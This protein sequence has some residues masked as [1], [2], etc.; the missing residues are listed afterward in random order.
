MKISR[1]IAA[2]CL[3]S[4]L[5]GGQSAPNSDA[6]GKLIDS[7]V[8]LQMKAE[9][10]PG[11]VLAITDRNRLLRVSTYG[12]ANVEAKVPATRDTLFEIGSISKSFT[13]I[14]LLQLR[15]QGKFDP[16][17]PITRYL[18]WFSI[19][20]KYRPITGHDIMTHTAGLP[21]DRDDVPSSLYQAAGVRDR[22]TGY[23]PGK[24]F[25]YSNIGYQI[26]GYVLQEITGKPYAETVRAHILQPLD[27]D[28]SDAVFT[29]DTYKR[30]AVGYAPLYDDR[31]YNPAE[32]LIPATWQEYAAGDGSVVSTAPDL[33]KY[34]RMLLNH[35]A[36]PSG[37]I[38]SEESWKLLTQPAAKVPGEENTYYGYGIFSRTVE[39]HRYIGHS[40]G[41][42]GYSARMEGDLDSGLGVV[43]LENAPLGPEDIA[44]FALQVMRAA[45]EGKPLPPLPQA[46]PVVKDAADYAGTYTAADGS[47]FSISNDGGRLGLDY[48]GQKLTLQARGQDLFFVNHPDFKLFNLSFGRDKGKIVEAF[49][50]DE[51]FT[52][53]RYVGLR[54]FPYP[55]QW[56]SYLGHYRGAPDNFRVVL[57]KGKLWLISAEGDEMMLTPMPGYF[58]LAHQGQPARERITFDTPVHGKTLRATLSGVAYY[59]TFTP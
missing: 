45:A 41:M 2:V 14:A 30:L 40:G 1:L 37:R 32:P 57:R 58:A 36:G 25:A 15:E 33:A 17:Q 8:A 27:M 26:M 35:G 4:S 28:H 13:A 19:R 23:E 18:P 21:R 38:V 34:L 50:G 54:Q 49:Y 16:R 22:W 48:K 47:N 59:R 53:E 20:T 42:T 31:P 46:A 12:Y 29:N 44:S 55:P 43:A 39:G 7:Y 6:A 5:A 56:A 11:L 24:Y 51:W 52:N 10:V 3:V 9:Q